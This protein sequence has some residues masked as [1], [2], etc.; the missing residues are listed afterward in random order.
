MTIEGTICQDP[1]KIN[2]FEKVAQK[3]LPGSSRSF[4]A[5]GAIIKAHFAEGESLH[6]QFLSRELRAHLPRGSSLVTLSM[7]NFKLQNCDNPPDIYL[8]RHFL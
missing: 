7:I 5:E 1:Q 6:P 4:G 2:F 3:F 8:N